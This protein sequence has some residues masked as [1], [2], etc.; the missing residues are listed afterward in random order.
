MSLLTLVQNASLS[1]GLASPATVIGN[2]TQQ[3]MLALAQL[4]GQDLRS[5]GQWTVLKRAN[6]FTLST[7]SVN[8]GAMNGTVVTAGDYDYMLAETFWNLDLRQPIIG[9]LSEVEE[10]ALIAI[11]IGGPFQQWTIRQGN[12]YIYEQPGTADDVVFQYMSTFYAKASGGT[13]KAA[14]TLDTDLCV[15]EESIMTLGLI[16]RWKRANGLDYAQEFDIYEKRVQEALS[17][18]A[19]GKKLYMDAPRWPPYGVIVPPGSWLQ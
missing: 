16:W 5:R 7:S 15:L 19:S 11:G 10:E 2:T 14:F 18:N 4:E 1:L 9:P 12:L 13:L 17:R 3:Q 8:Q 6:S